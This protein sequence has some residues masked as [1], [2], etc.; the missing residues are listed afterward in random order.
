[1]TRFPYPELLQLLFVSRYSLLFHLEPGQA[2]FFHQRLFDLVR[3]N[4]F[5]RGVGWQRPASS[6]PRR[7][8]KVPRTHLRFH[9]DQIELFEVDDDL[10][11]SFALG[12]RPEHARSVGMIDEA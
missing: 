12:V 1:M 7:P 2:V 9:P 11:A 3:P 4:A 6:P 8:S 5:L 10:M